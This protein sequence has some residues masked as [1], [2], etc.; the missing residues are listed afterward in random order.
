MCLRGRRRGLHFWCFSAKNCCEINGKAVITFSLQRA[1]QR[2]FELFTFFSSPV[3]LLGLMDWSFWMRTQP[4][5]CRKPA[6]TFNEML[7]RPTEQSAALIQEYFQ[8]F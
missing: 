3:V 2:C 7:K 8:V 4:A 5:G 1:R 6:P